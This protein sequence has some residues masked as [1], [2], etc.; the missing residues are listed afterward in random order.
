[1]SNKLKSFLLLIVVIF[2]ALPLA[3]HAAEKRTVKQLQFGKQV[4]DVGE[5]DVITF[6]G[7]NGRTQ[8]N[9]RYWNSHSLT[10]FKP[11]SGKSIEIVFSEV[12]MENVAPPAPDDD[13]DDDL[14]GAPAT[15]TF[16]YLN[17]YAGDPDANNSFKWATKK[18]EV[19]ATTVLPAG[20]I[21]GKLEGK[22]S[23]VSFLSE[24]ADDPISVGFI[25]FDASAT[26]WTATVRCVDNVKMTVAEAFA[27]FIIKFF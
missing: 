25:Y 2:M 16:T 3:G 27:C 19:T 4:I 21:L 7:V 22:Q 23:N 5:D 9:G 17:I 10:V 15:P 26:R 20:K 18:E 11:A 13:D 1:M 24:K 8:I 14:Y 12:S 6:Y